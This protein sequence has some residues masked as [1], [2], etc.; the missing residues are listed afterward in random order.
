M[1]GFSFLLILNH[2]FLN[3]WPFYDPIW[4]QLVANVDIQVSISTVARDIYLPL[5]PHDPET[6]LIRLHLHVVIWTHLANVAT[7]GNL[8]YAMCPLLSLSSGCNNTLDTLILASK[9]FHTF[10]FFRQ[11]SY[12]YFSFF[13]FPSLKHIQ[14]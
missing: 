10:V 6:G 11:I 13:G 7:T 2:S 1:V 5:T 8:L 12:F 4:M 14:K 9:K 3:T